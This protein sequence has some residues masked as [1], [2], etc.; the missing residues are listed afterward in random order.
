MLNEGNF[1]TDFAGTIH[2]EY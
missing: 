2:T 1:N